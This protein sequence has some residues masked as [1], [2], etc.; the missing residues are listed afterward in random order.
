[1]A[2]KLKNYQTSL[3]FYDLALAAPSIP[4]PPTPLT[5]G[6]SCGAGLST[7]AAKSFHLGV[8]FFVFVDQHIVGL[9]SR[10]SRDIKYCGLVLRRRNFRC[11][12]LAQLRG[13]RSS[14][15]TSKEITGPWCR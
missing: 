15:V 8:Q 9:R 1:M 6:S 14:I 3:G 13:W 4:V 10:L 5:H 7:T 11:C 12:T 2:R